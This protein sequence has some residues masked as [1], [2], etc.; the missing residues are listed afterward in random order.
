MSTGTL[1]ILVGSFVGITLGIL[2]LTG[3]IPLFSEPKKKKKKEEGPTSHHP[4]RA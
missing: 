2:I 4:G 3:V 1:L